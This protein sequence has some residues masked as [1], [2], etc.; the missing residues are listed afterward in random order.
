MSVFKRFAQRWANFKTHGEWKEHAASAAIGQLL[1]EQMDHQQA[2]NY[3][4]MSFS[5]KAG[6]QFVVTVRRH[7]GETPHQLRK[8]A[9]AEAFELLQ[10]QGR[11]IELAQTISVRKNDD[12]VWLHMKLESGA[13]GAVNLGED[14]RVVSQI[15]LHIEEMRQAALKAA[16]VK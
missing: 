10:V 9:E 12:G 7:D 5:N 8:L 4:E 14:V 3:I 13:A 6:D 2:P 11:L 1:S 16:G 15:A